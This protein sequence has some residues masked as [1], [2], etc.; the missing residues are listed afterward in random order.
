MKKVIIYRAADAFL[1]LPIYVAEHTRIFETK[2]SYMEVEFKTAEGDVD[3]IESMIQENDPSAVRIALGDPMA[4]FHNK[5]QPNQQS[6]RIV[7]TLIDKPPFW[8]ISRSEECPRELEKITEAKGCFDLVIHYKD[9]KLITGS[10][11][12]KIAAKE[13]GLDPVHDVKEVDYGQA[14]LSLKENQTFNS[15]CI[16]VTVDIVSLAQAQCNNG[17]VYLNYRFSKHFPNFLTSCL[18]TTA[19]V[20]KNHSPIITNVVEG[21]QRSI[22]VLR[23]SKEIA[24]EVCQIVNSQMVEKKCRPFET[25]QSD[26][27]NEYQIKNLRK[28]F[29][30]KNIE[31]SPNITI[32]GQNPNSNWLI[33]DEDS[34]RRHLIKKEK[35]HLYIYEDSG[36][37]KEKEISWIVD[38]FYLENFYH[39][40]LTTDEDKWIESIEARSWAQQWEDQEKEKLKKK[41]NTIVNNQFAEAAQ[42]KIIKEVKGISLQKAEGNFDQRKKYPHLF[43]YIMLTQVA[44][45]V[46]RAA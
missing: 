45:F 26:L 20:C 37:L 15:R 30:S 25:N 35:N 39:G 3:A 4:I 13:L 27:D 22:L 8:A 41:Y 1:Y 16:A 33:I 42:N 6:L 11:L 5:F 18:I 31:L 28:A 32:E 38:Q 43:T 44:T 2:D 46:Q 23:S 10:Y 40:N 7:G 29:A 21:I 17:G 19:E 24:K 14:M 36:G 12:G 9:K 34:E